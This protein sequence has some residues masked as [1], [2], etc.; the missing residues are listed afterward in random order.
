MVDVVVFSS[1]ALKDKDRERLLRRDDLL[2]NS[3]R[4]SSFINAYSNGFAKDDRAT[5][6]RETVSRVPGAR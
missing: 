4:I 3:R 6:N 5:V 1:T 2:L